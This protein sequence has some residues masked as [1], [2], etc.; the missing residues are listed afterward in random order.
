MTDIVD[1]LR[2]KGPGFGFYDHDPTFDLRID[3]AN[4][5]E[6]LRAGVTSKAAWDVIVE[7]ERRTPVDGWVPE[8]DD[9]HRNGEMAGAAACYAPRRAS[10]EMRLC[11]IFVIGL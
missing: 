6:R 10:C 2:A 11:P 3:A 8:H 4:E 9:E 1:R 7:R 5:I